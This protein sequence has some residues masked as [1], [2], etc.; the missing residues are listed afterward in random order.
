MRF[1]AALP[2]LPY[3]LFMACGGKFRR[4]RPNLIPTVDKSTAF[5]QL[6]LPRQQINPVSG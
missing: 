3:R 5:Q 4:H 2:S 1:G 6:L